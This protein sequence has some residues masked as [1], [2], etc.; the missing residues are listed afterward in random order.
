M[1]SEYPP[2]LYINHQP[3]TAI[4]RGDDAH[5]RIARW[6]YRLSEYDLDIVHVPG[7]K[8]AIADGLPRIASRIQPLRTEDSVN[9]PLLALAVREGILATASDPIAASLEN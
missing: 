9:L 5:G 3:L 7:R 4:W 2:K 1:G 6:Q 8:L